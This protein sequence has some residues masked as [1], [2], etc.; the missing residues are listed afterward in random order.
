MQQWPPLHIQSLQATQRRC[1]LQG[2][3]LLSK[4]K[5]VMK[6]LAYQ[7][8][9]G[10]GLPSSIPEAVSPHIEGDR[11][12]S[13]LGSSATRTSTIPLSLM[14]TRFHNEQMRM[15]N[16]DGPLMSGSKNKEFTPTQIRIKIVVKTLSVSVIECQGCSF[17]NWPS[18]HFVSV[19]DLH[20]PIED[21]T[22]YTMDLVSPRAASWARSSRGGS[23]DP[24]VQDD[25]Y[26][27]HDLS[28]AK[29]FK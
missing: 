1:L 3:W 5:L 28:W 29:V 9:G 22:P 15:W 4:G 23:L 13:E 6:K 12:Q 27:C 10:S 19:V 16:S 24:F 26:W 8:K 2:V 11:F 14:V 21:P 18:K 7:T 20:S 17:K 25:V